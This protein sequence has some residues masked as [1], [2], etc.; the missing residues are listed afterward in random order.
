MLTTL[1]E[2]SG[3]FWADSNCCHQLLDRVSGAGERA[4]YCRHV[5]Q[6]TQL[7]PHIAGM[8]SR[9]RPDLGMA[10]RVGQRAIPAGALAEHAAAPGTATSKALLDCRQHFIEQKVLP[11][12]H[13]SRIDVLVAAEPGEAI[14]KGDDDRRHALFA[15]QPVEPFRQVLAEADPIRVRQAAA[16]E[17]DKI[18]QQRQSL[19]IMSRREVH[20]HGA[21]RRV[22]EH[23]VL[24]GLALDRDAADGTRRPEK[25]AHLCPRLLRLVVNWPSLPR[26]VCRALAVV[27]TGRATA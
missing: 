13:R 7:E 5:G 8:T 6:I 27:E 2:P 14:G 17:A 15:D 3:C 16:G 4:Q 9:C 12:T 1:N 20:I 23:V 19:S 21:R 10:Q 18:H 11:N 24:E 26:W 25:L 22:T